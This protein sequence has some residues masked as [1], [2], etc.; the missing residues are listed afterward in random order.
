MNLIKEKYKNLIINLLLLK[1]NIKMVK[2]MELNQTTDNTQSTTYTENKII[3]M[4]KC[5]GNAFTTNW[6]EQLCSKKCIVKAESTGHSHIMIH[7]EML[8]KLVNL[9]MAS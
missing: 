2:K 7:K 4:I 9:K 8:F 3:R 5:T 6:M 1:P